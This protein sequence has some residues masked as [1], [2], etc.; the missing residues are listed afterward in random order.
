MRTPVAFDT[1]T[2]LI[3]Q[4]GKASTLTVPRMV[5]MSVAEEGE[6]PMLFERDRAVHVIKALFERDDIDLVGHNVAFDMLVVIRAVREELGVDLLP[7]AFE[8][9]DQG[10]IHD[11]QVRETLYDIERGGRFR[12]GSYSLSDLVSRRLGEKVAGKSGPDVWRLRYNELD[13]V[14]ADSYPTAAAEYALLDAVYTLRVFKHQPSY[15]PTAD[16]QAASDFVLSMISAWGVMI[17]YEWALAIDGWYARLESFALAE[18]KAFGLATSTGSIPRKPKQ[19][20]FIEGFH[21]LGLKPKLTP[22]GQVSTDK[23]AMSMLAKGGF[24]HPAFRALSDHSRA[25]KFRSTYLEPMLA[26]G[27]ANAPLCG[28]YN[29]SVDSTRTSASNPNL[30]NIVSRNNPIENVGIQWFHAIEGKMSPVER[31]T[32]PRGFALGTDIRGSIVARPGC[33]IVGA[34]YTAIELA[35]LAQVIANLGLWGPVG[36]L[37]PMGEAINAGDDLHLRVVAQIRSTSYEEVCAV[38]N[39]WKD[40]QKNGRVPEDFSIDFDRFTAKSA[41]YSFPVG[42]AASTWAANLRKMG[43]DMTDHR[44][45]DIKEAWFG[46]WPEMRVYRDYVSS[47]E[48]P[49]GM[50]VVDMH[51]PNRMTSGWAKRKTDRFTSAA[52]TFFQSIVASGAKLALQMI[53][54]GCYVEPESPLYGSRIIIFEHDAVY[55]ESPED[56]AE[57]AAAE[58]TKRMIAGMK[59]FLPDVVVEADADIYPERWC[60]K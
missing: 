34:D 29:V 27:E 38:H 30:Q 8:L 31:L 12:R 53:S 39:E 1:E 9:Y 55:L 5:C 36:T 28:R 56:K 20:L 37:A 41:N 15:I 25:T 11:T 46:A 43:V 14:H 23:E 32:H 54:R 22:K 49:D 7:R 57:E 13:G 45:E 2:F 47:L 50:Y 21:E 26:A 33:Q 60:H 58:L 4:T 24:V 35:G 19:A 51:G 48:Q 18:L 10:R 59:V 17:D 42:S 3:N 44:A 40:A 16:F 52:N 6:T